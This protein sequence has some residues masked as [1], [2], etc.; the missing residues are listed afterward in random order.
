MSCELLNRL[1]HSVGCCAGRF[2][3]TDYFEEQGY[4]GRPDCDGGRALIIWALTI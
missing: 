4:Q 3:V 1:C 2:V